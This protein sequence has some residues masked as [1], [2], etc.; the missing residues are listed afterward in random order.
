MSMLAKIL[1][2]AIAVGGVFT[3]GLAVI[4]LVGFFVAWIAMLVWGSLLHMT[5]WDVEYSLPFLSFWE[6]YMIIILLGIF[7]SFFKSSSSNGNG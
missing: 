4:A 3:F 1:I 5:G 7:G 6:T 2:G